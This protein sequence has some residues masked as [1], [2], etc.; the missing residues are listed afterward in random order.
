MVG[1]DRP[2]IDGGARSWRRN[3][4]VHIEF[5][6][7]VVNSA[8]VE[9]LSVLVGDLADDASARGVVFHLGCV[10]GGL[11]PVG[12][13]EPVGRLDP[14][15]A[16]LAPGDG[17]K[18]LTRLEKVL[19]AVERL[20]RPTA[21]VLEGPI[22]SVGLELALIADLTIASPDVVFYVPGPERGFLP[23]MSLYRL[24]R[25]VGP[26]IARQILL[27]RTT[28]PAQH[29][30]RLGIVDRIVPVPTE[31]LGA[32]LSRL[33]SL[34][35]AALNLARQMLT[36]AGP[37]NYAEAYD[38]YKAAQ[39]HVLHSLA[40]GS[41][42]AAPDAQYSAAEYVT[43]PFGAGPDGGD[44]NADDSASVVRRLDDAGITGAVLYPANVFRAYGRPP[45][46]DL[47]ALL[48]RYND[49]VLGLCAGDEKRL[50]PAVLL[51]VDDPVAAASEVRR[52]AAAGAAAAVI[53][54]FPHNEQR[55]DSP[56]Y[57]PLWSAL[58]Q[59][60][61]PI[62]LHRG[63][64][65]HVGADARPFDL[66]LHRVEGSDDVFD[67]VF[68]ALEGSYARL[69]VVA[70]IL[71]GVF[72]RHPG[73]KVVIVDF[74]LAW[75][76]YTLM[77]L[78][79]QYEVRPERAGPPVETNALSGALASHWLPSEHA[80]FQFADD[81]RPSDHFRRHVFVA[82][83]D[84]PLGVALLDILGPRN[85]LWAGQLRPDAAVGPPRR[86]QGLTAEERATVERRNAVCMYGF[87]PNGVAG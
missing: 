68:D 2:G 35:P 31:A 77:R 69:A 51:D 83:D 18:A 40:D 27:H 11:E 5:I 19:A 76:P 55:Y 1:H 44:D 29:A 15:I 52:T 24:V 42:G 41:T 13:F 46:A 20:P 12:R 39:F 67:Q 70:M 72:D 30:R 80:G 87:A 6:E 78:D 56:R 61:L 8:V 75:A 4:I 66:A 23:G 71:S 53:P 57:A 49:W 25:Y 50:R 82:V 9:S 84:D 36:E 26:G 63:T 65:R 48:S 59:S 81:E 22:G 33:L 3:D 21:V 62:T 37:M 16:D 85:I 43:A 58:E 45:G 14:T 34:P 28:I 79:E 47:T 7:A 32:E 17:L 64:C 73:L 86:M 38:S 60:G 54:L 10:R 74:G